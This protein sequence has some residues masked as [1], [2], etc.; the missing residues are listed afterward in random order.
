M[1][2]HEK[3]GETEL[4]EVN[5]GEEVNSEIQNLLLWC[6]SGFQNIFIW[7]YLVKVSQT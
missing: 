3:Y 5:A 6:I 4:S 7:N 2:S 1:K